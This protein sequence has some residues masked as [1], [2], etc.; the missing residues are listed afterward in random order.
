[1]M[2]D[3]IGIATIASAV[4]VLAVA[5]GAVA[6]PV[7]VDSVADQQPGD[8][9]YG[10]EK[11]GE[12]IKGAI[13]DGEQNWHLERAEERIQE[14]QAAAEGGN[15][16]EYKEVLDEGS[17]RFSK[18]VTRSDNIDGLER[19]GR[20][21]GRNIQLLENLE[22]RVPENAR[23]AIE[24]AINRSR[25]QVKAL[26]ETRNKLGNGR[27]PPGKFK[28]ELENQIDTVDNLLNSLE[29]ERLPP[30]I[31]KE[32]LEN[33][34]ISLE[35]LKKMINGRNLPP[36]VLKEIVSDMDLTRGEREDLLDGMNLPPGIRKQILEEDDIEYGE[37]DRDEGESGGLEDDEGETENREP[38]DFVHE[39]GDLPDRGSRRPSWGE[40]DEGDDDMETDAGYEILEDG[41]KIPTS[42][43][44]YMVNPA[45]EEDLNADLVVGE[46]KE[47][48]ETWDSHTSTE[49]F[50][51]DVTVT[52]KS[53]FE[54]DGDNVI[55]F[56]PLEDFEQVA[57]TKVWYEDDKILE[58]DIV[59][60]TSVDWGVDPDG[61]GPS[62][63][64][65]YDIQNIATHEA[66]HTLALQ[67]ID[68]DEF[69]HLTMYYRSEV[70]GTN[71]IS[72]ENGDIDGL[73]ALYGE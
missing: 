29:D 58:F 33:R 61:E 71:K 51:N 40:E 43:A 26:E 44:S 19:A 14:Y 55:S 3:Q 49:L 13:I 65:A 18:A 7:A 60:N 42:S 23:P 5:S 25:M 70:G 12:S 54:R 22:N 46:I 2:K 24:R 10:L 57:L 59:F 39:R 36:G 67:D 30:G 63:I 53:G 48:F 45:T 28:E 35:D 72:L 6:L 32:V 66:G 52:E 38:D 56:A 73:H 62:T 8:S 16:E 69:S 64:D 37:D 21:I 17:N 47:A 41:V 9:L 11:A 1:M 68:E 34:D 27:T 50:D 31:L 4:A 15:G 20:A